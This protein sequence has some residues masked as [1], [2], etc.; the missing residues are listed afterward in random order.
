MTAKRVIALVLSLA[1]IC[2]AL[3]MLVACGGNDNTVTTKPASTTA[4]P[5]TDGGTQNTSPVTTTAAAPEIV[6]PTVEV[7]LDGDVISFVIADTDGDKFNNR[8]IFA[9]ED[10][11]DPVDSVICERNEAVMERFN[12][13]LIMYEEY[14][15]DYSVNAKYGDLLLSNTDEIDIIA[16]RQWDDAQLATKGYLADLSAI[17]EGYINYDQGY[18]ATDYIEGMNYKDKVYWVVGDLNLRYTGGFYT[19]FVNQ[20]LYNKNCAAIYGD[21]LY[22]L[23]KA[24]NGA[25]GGWT[26]DTVIA[27]AALGWVDEGSKS[28]VTDADDVLGLAIP[29]WD[30]TNGMVVA[31]GI[32]F[33]TENADGSITVNITNSNKR[34]SSFNAKIVELLSTKGVYSYGG[35]Y[36]GAMAKLASDTAMMVFGRLN[37]AEL[38]LTEMESG[39]YILPYPKLDENQERYYSSVHDGISIFGI[40]ASSAKVKEAAAVLDY[41]AFLSY[42]KVRGEYYEYALKYRYTSDDGATAEMI[43]IIAKSATSDIVYVWCFSEKFGKVYSLGSLFR[44]CLT[45]SSTSALTSQI[46]KAGKSWQTAADS[47]VT[48]FEELW[49]SQA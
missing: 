20:T 1:M 5:G 21:N 9:D 24:G 19:V 10:T 47:L 23:V 4:A 13:E 7:D 25:K 35:N 32:P 40:N 43:D 27:M 2:G 42:T 22:D 16:G 45:G 36:G 34:L 8:S 18:W 44:A 31:A 48:D 41:M 15:S 11:G 17:E 46:K 3:A 14:T 6:E 12:C 49:A 37:Q 30:N 39:Y 26:Y 38:Y 33:G 29:M 28:E